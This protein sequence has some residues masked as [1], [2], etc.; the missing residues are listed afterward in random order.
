MKSPKKVKV[1]G[2]AASSSASSAASPV[3]SSNFGMTAVSDRHVVHK[4]LH[5][6]G[7]S[8]VGGTEYPSAQA[9]RV[10]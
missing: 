3:A 10:Q 7:G 2:A 4:Q 1:D 9:L 5:R 8:D 6:E